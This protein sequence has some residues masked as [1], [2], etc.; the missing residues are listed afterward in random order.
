MLNQIDRS[1]RV[2]LVFLAS[3]AEGG[4]A[5]PKQNFG[6]LYCRWGDAELGAMDFHWVLFH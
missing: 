3:L 1:F 4:G 2:E 6:L 5:Q